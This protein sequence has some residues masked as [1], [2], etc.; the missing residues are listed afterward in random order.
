MIKPNFEDSDDE[1]K[2]FDYVLKDYGGFLPSTYS[3]W[4][5]KDLKLKPF[6]KYIGEDP[7]ISYVAIRGDEQREAYV[8]TKDNVQTIFPFKKNIWSFDVLDL[9]LDYHNIGQLKDIYERIVQPENID[10]II[11]E[12]ER[13][14]SIEHNFNKKVDA[15]I[16]LDTT[17]FNRTVFHFL[18]KTDFPLGKI[19]NEE[20]F[21][22]LDKSHILPSEQIIVRE[23]VFEMLEDSIGVPEYYKKIEYEVDG[24]KGIYSRTRSGC[25]FCFYQ[26]KIEWIWLYENNPE[27]FKKAQRYEKDGFTW[28]ENESLDDLIHP[29]RIRDIK[30]KHIDKKQSVSSKKSKTLLNNLLGDEEKGDYFDKEDEDYAGCTVCFI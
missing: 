28:I 22:I 7:T 29:D 19:E 27:L 18:K 1:M 20:D 25:F 10:R 14:I 24:K 15:L 3:R 16:D 30:L 8:S 12:V 17:A 5:T 11:A 2:P 23:Q 9:V 6:E 21:P 13:P 4:C 26:Q